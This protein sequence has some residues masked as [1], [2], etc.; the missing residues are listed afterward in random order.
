MFLVNYLDPN[1]MKKI[2]DK[3]NG[4]FPVPDFDSLCMVHENILVAKEMND[5]YHQ[6]I[7]FRELIAQKK[8]IEEITKI[9]GAKYFQLPITQRIF[10]ILGN[11][12]MS[13]HVA[14]G[15]FHFGYV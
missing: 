5:L 13:I 8:S 6:R 4:F 9:L 7:D 2:K 3:M 12:H 11:E 14:P 10:W 1:E 15:V